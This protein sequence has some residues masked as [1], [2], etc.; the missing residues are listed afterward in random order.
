MKTLTETIATFIH[1]EPMSTLIT[2]KLC[3]LVICKHK[4][5]I[6]DNAVTYFQ[7]SMSILKLKSSLPN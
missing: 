1:S 7:S 4:I 6:V 5:Q 2:D 3:T